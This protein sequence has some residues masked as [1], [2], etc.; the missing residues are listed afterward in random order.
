[1]VNA[2]WMETRKEAKGSFSLAGK[3]DMVSVSLMGEVVRFL[4]ALI[5]VS[6][7]IIVQRLIVDQQ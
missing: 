3:F 6:L 2:L 4:R 1:M 5:P 7:W